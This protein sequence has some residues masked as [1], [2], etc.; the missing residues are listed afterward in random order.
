MRRDGVCECV[1][2]R[3]GKQQY[4]VGGDEQ[5]SAGAYRH[6]LTYKRA[7]CDTNVTLATLDK[8][9]GRVKKEKKYMGKQL[10]RQFRCRFE[11]LEVDAV[12]PF[13]DRGPIGLL[14][15]N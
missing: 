12:R 13:D 2:A 10:T 9:C 8:E 15:N 6:S 1:A 4:C 5:P 14:G 3:P 7:S 11:F